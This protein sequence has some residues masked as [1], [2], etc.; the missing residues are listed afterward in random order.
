MDPPSR[1]AIIRHL[2]PPVILPPTDPPSAPSGFID[3]LQNSNLI[4]T[5]PFPDVVVSSGGAQLIELDD[6]DE[7]EPHA[8]LTNPPAEPNSGAL[9]SVRSISADRR[10]S[11]DQMVVGPQ[12]KKPYPL[13]PIRASLI[14]R[15]TRAPNRHNPV[16]GNNNTGRVGKLRCGQCRKWRRKVFLL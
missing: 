5:D 14:N 2:W 11:N 15:R 9:V 3:H 16:S 10:G 7:S 6:Q 1:A 4:L 13:L 8:F 12:L